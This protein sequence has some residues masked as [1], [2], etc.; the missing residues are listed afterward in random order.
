MT[1]TSIILQ[2]L[3]AL[4]YGALLFLYYYWFKEI[5]NRISILQQS[6]LRLLEAFGEALDRQREKEE[7]K[8]GDKPNSPYDNQQVKV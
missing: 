5:D 4:A 3:N 8:D 6:H 7:E 1:I 2:L